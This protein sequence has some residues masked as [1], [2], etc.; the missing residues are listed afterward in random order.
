MEE[1]SKECFNNAI[2]VIRQYKT[3]K[4]TKILKSEYTCICCKEKKIK[5][6]DSSILSLD[7]TKNM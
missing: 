3:Q 7:P 2:D 4:L 5:I 1:I 6:Y